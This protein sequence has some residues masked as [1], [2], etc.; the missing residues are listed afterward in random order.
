MNGGESDAMWK[1]YGNPGGET[2]AIKTTIGHLIKALEKSPSIPVFV[3]K[4]KYDERS[5]PEGNLYLPVVY[6]RRPF[7]HER[8]VRL[9][10][11]SASSD[12]PPSVGSFKQEADFLGIRYNS[13][14]EILKLVGEKGLSVK[15]NLDMLVR[16]IVIHPDGKSSF[17]EAVR[18]VAKTKVPHVRIRQSKMRPYVQ[19]GPVGRKNKKR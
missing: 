2:V 11:G 13:D 19:S 18:Y 7:R 10:I 14:G 9:C 3:G 15:V 4:V 8:E 12:N 17:L 5:K 1:V 6:K 16:E